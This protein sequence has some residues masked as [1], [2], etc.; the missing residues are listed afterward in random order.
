MKA[1]TLVVSVI[2]AAVL[3]VPGSAVPG[4]P[5]PTTCT[6]LLTG[7]IIGDVVVPAG[8]TCFIHD[9]TISGSVNVQTDATVFFTTGETFT[10]VRG[11]VR[12][13]NCSSILVTP[14]PFISPNVVI[15][16]D[17]VAENCSDG[18]DVGSALIGG[19]VICKNA[20]NAQDACSMFSSFISGNVDCSGNS[21]GCTLRGSQIGG[22]AKLNNNTVIELG[23]NL[24]AGNLKCGGNG[25]VSG[26][27][28]SNIVAGTKSGDCSGL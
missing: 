15:G 20:T 18:L 22:D 5:P 14:F 25:S 6:S 11:N 28:G 12:G 27:A 19:N 17:L 3:G 26:F 1:W 10:T 4:P 23:G 16:G 9:A 7:S 21:G 13:K 8:E 24:I 2:I